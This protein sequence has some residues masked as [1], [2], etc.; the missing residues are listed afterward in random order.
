MA[1]YCFAWICS[2]VYSY[3]GLC[4]A[5]Y[6]PVGLCMAMYW[7]AALQ[8]ATILLAMACKKNIWQLKLT[9]VVNWRPTDY[10]RNL[11]GKLID[12]WSNYQK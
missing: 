2:A 11:L 3:I 6:G 9:K 5:V 7:R 8:A 1:M 10:E 4:T 12:V